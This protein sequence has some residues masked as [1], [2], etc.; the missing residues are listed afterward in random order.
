MRST[1]PTTHAVCST[2]NAMRPTAT[3]SALSRLLPSKATMLL[4]LP[5]TIWMLSLEVL[6][7]LLSIGL[8]QAQVR[9]CLPATELLPH[10]TTSTY[11]LM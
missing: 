4:V 8:L 10:S 6:P 11:V 9:Y 5:A 7:Q 2:T 3:A 1:N